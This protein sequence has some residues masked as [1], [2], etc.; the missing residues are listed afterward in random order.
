MAVL[1]DSDTDAAPPPSV[2]AGVRLQ[3]LCI[4]TELSRLVAIVAAGRLPATLEAAARV[5]V[6][7]AQRKSE[8]IVGGIGTIIYVSL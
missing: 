4:L 2:L 3:L 6:P 5:K 1:E 7:G 8:E